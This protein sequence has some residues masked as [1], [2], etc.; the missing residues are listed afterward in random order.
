M[1]RLSLKGCTDSVSEEWTPGLPGRCITWCEKQHG[2]GLWEL[3]SD[4]IWGYV[5]V[6]E[7]WK[8]IISCLC[9]RKIT[10]LWSNLMESL[11]FPFTSQSVF[12]R[13]HTPGAWM[14]VFGVKQRDSPHDLRGLLIWGLLDSYQ[15]EYPSHPSMTSVLKTHSSQPRPKLHIPLRSD[16]ES[17]CISSLLPPHK[18][19]SFGHAERNAREW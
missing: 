4:C 15:Y 5:R 9:R 6:C 3:V 1:P 14:G 8:T 19:M 16:A 12:Q 17:G 10:C 18:G 7:Y 13:K 2:V 11:P